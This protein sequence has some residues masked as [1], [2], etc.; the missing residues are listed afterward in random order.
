MQK[1]VLEVMVTLVSLGCVHTP[2][3][4]F[5]SSISTYDAVS[6]CNVCLLSWY[7]HFCDVFYNVSCMLCIVLTYIIGARNLII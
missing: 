7:Q 4:Y 3:Q 6:V 5:I 1:E 2:M